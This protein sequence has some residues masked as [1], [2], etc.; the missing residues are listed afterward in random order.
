[1]TMNDELENDPKQ[2][3]TFGFMFSG[4]I[5][6]IFGL[7]LPYF[8]EYSYPIWPWAVGAT[9]IMVT[10]F[11]PRVLGVLFRIWMGF[12][13]I[14]NAIMSRL[15]LGVVFFMVILPIGLVLRLLGKRPL[16]LS[17]PDN[18]DTYR[19]SSANRSSKSMENPY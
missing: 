1:M 13:M 16:E 14:M 3:R 9:M 10:M 7:I 12:G 2:M 5:A 15:I 17:S 4:M 19:K 8:I 18:A 6:V 11:L